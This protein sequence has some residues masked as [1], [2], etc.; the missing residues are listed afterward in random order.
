M[1]FFRRRRRNRKRQPIRWKQRGRQVL[2][3]ALVFALLGVLTVLFPTQQQHEYSAFREGAIAPDEVIA[4]TTFPVHKSA[5]TYQSEVE[6]ARRQVLP[7]LRYDDAVQQNMQ[8]ALSTF[9]RDTEK[10]RSQT[11][12]DSLSNA[13]HLSHPEIGPLSES[14]LQ[15]LVPQSRRRSPARRKLIATVDSMLQST[16]QNGVIEIGRAHV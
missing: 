9:L 15:F 4:P 10:H 13:L 2:R 16:Y 8:K 12:T 6:T 7:I 11:L 5:A 1:M 3:V 14:T